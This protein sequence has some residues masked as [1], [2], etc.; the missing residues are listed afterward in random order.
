MIAYELL[1]GRPPFVA[2][3]PV[4]LLYAHVHTRA[5]AARGARRA[6]ARRDLR[7]GRVA[8]RQGPRRPPAVGGGGMGRA[9]G[10]GGRGDGPVLAPPRGDHRAGARGG[11][12]RRGREPATTERRRARTRRASSPTPTP[13]APPA[14]GPRARAG[15]GAG[16]GRG[17]GGARR[18]RPRSPA[19]VVPDDRE[20]ADPP[21]SRRRA[22]DARPR[23]RTTSTRDGRQELV[24]ALL[25]GAPRGRSAHSGVVLVQHRGRQAAVETITEARAGV[26]GRPADGDDFGSGLASGDFDRDGHADLAIGTPGRE[27]VSVLYGA[28]A[29]STTAAPSSSR[30]AARGCRR[31]RSLRLRA[32]GP[33]PRRRRL[34]RPRGRRA[35][36]ARRAAVAAARCTS[37]SA[38][39][40][41]CAGPR[42]RHPAPGPAMAGFG[43]RL[44]VGRRR[45][46]RAARPRGGRPAARRGAGHATYCRSGAAR[47]RALPRCCRRPGA[48]RAS[49]S[50]TSTATAAPTSSRAT[51]STSTRRRPPVGRGLVRVWFG[52]RDGPRPTPLEITQDTPTIPGVDEPGRRVRR[53]RGGRRH[54]LG[55]VRGHDRRAPSREDER[56]RPA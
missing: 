20:P 17:R 13:L 30:A 55:R 32:G 14:V 21:A 29:G 27:R 45:R 4:G 33:R 8:A 48:P 6:R 5:A 2:D 36:R 25:R 38:A 53:R 11:A 3:T 40:G 39:P 42:A 47:A 44:R 16:R 18:G 41:A 10:A 52:S 22:P 43:M 51:P 1:A 23:R 7:L 35:R 46:R 12:A 34:R 28:A 19:F 50:A 37:S 9:R 26:P 15:A 56:R 31:R 49:R 54:G 24:I